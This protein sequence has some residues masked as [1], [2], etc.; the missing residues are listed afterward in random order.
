MHSAFTLPSMLAL[1]TTSSHTF[2]PV[3]PLIPL[4]ESRWVAAWCWA[5]AGVK[6]QQFS[7]GVVKKQDLSVGIVFS[8]YHISHDLT[9]AL[10]QESSSGIR[11]KNFY[12]SFVVQVSVYSIV[13]GHTVYH[14]FS[15]LFSFFL[16]CGDAWEAVFPYSLAFAI[17]ALQSHGSSLTALCPS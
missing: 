17:V 15:S 16:P 14:E 1:E 3:L 7:R 4:G 13:G 11:G 2:F 8:G 5:D 6:P 10:L 9:C 12:S